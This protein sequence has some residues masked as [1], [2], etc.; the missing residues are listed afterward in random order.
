MR[1]SKKRPTDFLTDKGA[2]FLYVCHQLSS[3]YFWD[4]IRFIIAT[5][6]R[7]T[8]TSEYF[9]WYIHMYNES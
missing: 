1:R 8:L 3:S 7:C 5:I 2:R 6:R 9:C 4:V